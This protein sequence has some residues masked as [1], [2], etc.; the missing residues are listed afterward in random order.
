MKRLTV[1]L[2]MHAPAFRNTLKEREL[3]LRGNKIPRIENL[4]ATQDQFD[5]IDFSN[6]QIEILEDFPILRRCGTLLFNNNIV[7][8]ISPNFADSLPN[9]HTLMLTNNDIRTFQQLVPLEKCKNLVRLSLYLNPVS[10]LPNYR[11][12][13]F[14]LITSLNYLDF[15]KIT[16]QE[17][18]QAAVILDTLEVTR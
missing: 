1:E 16:A 8:Q 4:G 18:E 15:Q 7:R 2:I 3:D 9:L 13:T 11:L 6:N 17:R 5:V 10:T 12:I 14:R